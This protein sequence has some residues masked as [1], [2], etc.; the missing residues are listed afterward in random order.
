MGVRAVVFDVGGVLAL[1]EPMDFDARWERDLG[2]EAGTIGALLADVWEAGAV[3]A[4]TEDEVHAAVGERLG[5]APARVDAVMADMW[6]QYLGRANT[7]LIAFVRGLRPAY[8]TGI[9]SNSFV[10]AREREQERYGFGDLVDEVIYSHEAGMNKPD[11]RL[12]ELACRRM[13]VAP[14][15]MV[16]VD[17]A[18]HLVASARAFGMHAVLFEDSA[19]VIREVGALLG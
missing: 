6:R 2:L 13:A 4:V 14:A 16:F 8:R 5:L 10:G 18:P 19:Q 11:P 17:N 15:E 1:V 12:W 9:L 7:E 3:G